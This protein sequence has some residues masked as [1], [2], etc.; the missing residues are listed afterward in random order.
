MKVYQVWRAAFS[1]KATIPPAQAV[2]MYNESIQ[3][4]TE[5]QSILVD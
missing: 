3:G 5:A 4:N 1:G 2:D